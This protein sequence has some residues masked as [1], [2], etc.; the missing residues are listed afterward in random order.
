[1]WGREGEKERDGLGQTLD[2]GDVD[3]SFMVLV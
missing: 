1:M 2:A 3:P